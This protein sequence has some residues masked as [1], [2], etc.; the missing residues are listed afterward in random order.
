LGEG[1]QASR[2]TQN[3]HQIPCLVYRENLPRPCTYVQTVGELFHDQDIPSGFP[4][5]LMEKMRS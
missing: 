3:Y 1:P 5:E 2:N 4:R